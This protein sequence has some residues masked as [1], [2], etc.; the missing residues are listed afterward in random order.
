MAGNA[1]DDEAR[2]RELAYFLWKD[3]G[4]PEGM[5]GAHWEQAS[6]MLSGQASGGEPLEIQAAA[7]AKAG[8]EAEAVAAKARRPKVIGT[9]AAEVKTE[10]KKASSKAEKAPK[11]DKPAKKPKAKA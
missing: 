3:A 10:S 11:A 5:A 4:S 7:A 1:P 2:I 8:K 9:A 6:R